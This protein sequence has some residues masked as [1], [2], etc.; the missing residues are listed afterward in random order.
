MLLFWK[1]GSTSPQTNLYSDQYSSPLHAHTHRRHTLNSSH[2]KLLKNE[3][4][5][6]LAVVA[7]AKR[8]E[9]QPGRV[10]VVTACGMR[11]FPAEFGTES[12]QLSKYGK[13]ITR[14]TSSLNL[15]LDYMP[16]DPST[17]III[18]N[19]PLHKASP[20]LG[21][22]ARVIIIVVQVRGDHRERER[23]RVRLRGRH[24]RLRI[25]AAYRRIVCA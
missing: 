17:P 14:E 7:L 22:R 21:L 11:E 12:A 1:A 16:R 19:R 23:E 24:A 18:Q 8:P 6:S 13:S 9:L 15:G 20:F 4:V 3:Q 5:A 10:T 2:P 25:G